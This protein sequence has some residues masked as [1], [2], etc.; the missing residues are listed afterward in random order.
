A[1]IHQARERIAAGAHFHLPRQRTLFGYVLYHDHAADQ[2]LLA[3]EDGRRGNVHGQLGLAVANQQNIVPELD[4]LADTDGPKDR[5][6]QGTALFLV[7]QVQHLGD[8]HADAIVPFQTGQASR[9]RVEVLNET[10]LVSR[11]DALGD[12]VQRQLQTLGFLGGGLK[13]LLEDG[14]VVEQI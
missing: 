2:G 1:A 7:Q 13:L 11:N 3:V 14:D 6:G 5:I 10:V 9:Q 12:T 4:G 8:R